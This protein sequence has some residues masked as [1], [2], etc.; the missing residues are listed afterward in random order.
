MLSV[1]IAFQ[2]KCNTSFSFP[3]LPLFLY[4]F[5]F[6]SLPL[7]LS[8]TPSLPLHLAPLFLN[9]PLFLLVYFFSC[10]QNSMFNLNIIRRIRKNEHSPHLHKRKKREIEKTC[11]MCLYVLG[12]MCIVYDLILHF[13]MYNFASFNVDLRICH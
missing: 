4:L 7:S 3:F 10:S 8:H 9:F 12:W 2:F 1:Q 13:N 5:S 11:V 6:T